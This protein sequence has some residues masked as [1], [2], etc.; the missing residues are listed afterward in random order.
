MQIT[1]KDDKADMAFRMRAVIDHLNSKNSEVLSNDSE[2]SID[3][4]IQRQIWN[5]AVHKIKTNKMGLEIL[6]SLFE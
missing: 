3:G 2:Q 1:E 6:V 5:E 4:E